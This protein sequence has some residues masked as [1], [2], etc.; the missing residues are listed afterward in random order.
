[1]EFSYSGGGTMEL[2]RCSRCQIAWFDGG[3]LRIFHGHFQFG[4]PPP[5]EKEKAG[6]SEDSE[7]ADR[8][9]DES[10]IDV[11]EFDPTSL[12]FLLTDLPQ[13]ENPV[14]VKK[15]IPV[16]NFLLVAL[17]WYFLSCIETPLSFKPW[18][19]FQPIRFANTG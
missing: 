9:A 6:V 17:C 12:F 16:T 2:D 3:E 19:S 7:D 10:Y 14:T 18:G 13:E 1:M 15:E 5:E 4:T 8:I 11:E